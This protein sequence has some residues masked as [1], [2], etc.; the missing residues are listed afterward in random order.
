MLDGR[1]QI[2]LE[3]ATRLEQSKDM[4][5]VELRN[6]WQQTMVCF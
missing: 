5:G 4:R 2:A 3:F 6:W 1:A